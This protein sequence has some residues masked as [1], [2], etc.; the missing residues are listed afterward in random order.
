MKAVTSVS[1]EHFKLQH[2][3]TTVVVGTRHITG[4]G[5]GSNLKAAN[6]NKTAMCPIILTPCLHL[7]YRNT[8]F[9]QAN[10]L[11]GSVL[12]THFCFLFTILIIIHTIISTGWGP[13]FNITRAM[14]NSIILVITRWSQTVPLL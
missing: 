1:I 6:R 12:V 9:K 2:I 8:K 3:L 5:C 4:V 14:D 7:Y 10:L 11:L 13:I